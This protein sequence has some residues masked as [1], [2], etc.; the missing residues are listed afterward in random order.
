MRR[1]IHNCEKC[2]NYIP[3]FHEERLNKKLPKTEGDQFIWVGSSGDISFIEDTQ[4][5]MILD[6]IREYPEKTFFLQTKN[7]EWYDGWVF[8]VN[9]LLGITLESDIH[10]PD[11]SE[12]PKPWK[13]ASDFYFI[14]H[15]RKVITIEPILKF[16]IKKLFTW[17]RDI[18]PERVYIGYDSKK[19]Q[20]P[21]PTYQETMDLI[22]NLR[23]ITVVKE[24][25]IRE[26]WDWT[27]PYDY[28][29][30]EVYRRKKINYE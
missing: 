2:G 26:S 18:R 30:D 27:N 5:Q 1:Q 8:P 13:R 28:S 10:Y 9:V 17:I 14:N 25:L 21:E 24:K 4:F 12:A 6:K 3:H 22:N 7:P 19:N 23:K 29:L 20:L 16:N 15:P 11:I